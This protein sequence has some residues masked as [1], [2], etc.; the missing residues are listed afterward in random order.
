MNSYD[1]P[2]PQK[3]Q[4]ISKPFS[5]DIGMSEEANRLTRDFLG[6]GEIVRTMSGGG[7]GFSSSQ[8]Q[9]SS[10]DNNNNFESRKNQSHHQQQP[11]GGGT[12]Q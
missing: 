4:M 10:L 2:P 11:F 3:K 7:G 6:V 1:Q 9:M 5:M 12:F 8:Q